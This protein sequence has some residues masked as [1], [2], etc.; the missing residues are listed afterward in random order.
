MNP[1]LDEDEIRLPTAF[2]LLTAIRKTTGKIAQKAGERALLE[3]TAIELRR[4]MDMAS[5]EPGHTQSM[6]WGDCAADMEHGTVDYRNS[7]KAQKSGAYD[8]LDDEQE[9]EHAAPSMGLDRELY[10]DETTGEFVIGKLQ[11]SRS[12]CRKELRT[13]W[14]PYKAPE[15]RCSGALYGSQIVRN[16]FRHLLRDR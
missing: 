4:D 14:E 10:I 1:V 7:H 8:S 9:S 16:S 15:L 3:A 12:R 2:P 11:R 13:I 6:L 5:T